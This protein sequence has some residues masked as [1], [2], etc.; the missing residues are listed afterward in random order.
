MGN[1]Q[2]A[3]D[4]LQRVIGDSDESKAGSEGLKKFIC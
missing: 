2:R 4:N 3:I 1:K